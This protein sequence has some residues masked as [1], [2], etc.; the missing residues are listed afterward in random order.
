MVF[1]EDGSWTRPLRLVEKEKLLVLV[2]HDESIFNAND[3][4]K[5]V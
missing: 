5:R 1:S 4:K 2:I 3:G